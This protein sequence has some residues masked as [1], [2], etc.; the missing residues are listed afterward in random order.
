[1]WMCIGKLYRKG[2]GN[3][4]RSEIIEMVWTWG[5]NG[6]VQYGYKGVDSRCK[7]KLGMG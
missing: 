3:L 4:S 5:E 1:M 6:S 2:V 7:W